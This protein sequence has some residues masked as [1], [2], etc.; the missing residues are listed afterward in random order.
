MKSNYYDNIL[1]QLRGICG[2]ET[3]GEMS[4]CWNTVD[5]DIDRE[6]ESYMAAEEEIKVIEQEIEKSGHRRGSAGQIGAEGEKTA[7]EMELEEVERE[8]AKEKDNLGQ[9]EGK[10]TGLIDL[11]CQR[12]SD[13]EISNHILRIKRRAGSNPREL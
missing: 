6:Y 13:E 11:N 10:L 3:M 1:L 9:L 12:L 8:M 7:E 5:G 2:G 4:D